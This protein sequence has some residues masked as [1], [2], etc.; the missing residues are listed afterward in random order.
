M[1]VP[2]PENFAAIKSCVETVWDSQRPVVFWIGAGASAWYGLPLWPELAETLYRKFQSRLKKD[3]RAL[4]Q[5]ALAAKQFP[6]LF[7]LSRA[8]DS[9]LYLQT[10]MNELRTPAD[11]PSAYSRFIKA[12]CANK[13]TQIV[14]TNVD[15]CLEQCSDLPSVLHGDIEQVLRDQHPDGWMLHLHLND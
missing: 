7:S 11:M 9:Q 14:T 1:F 15:Q 2:T 3:Q 4:A 13:P 6:A 12:I 5:E 8:E 10:I